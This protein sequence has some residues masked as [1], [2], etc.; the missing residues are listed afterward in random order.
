MNKKPDIPAF[1]SNG[2]IYLRA[3]STGIF[4]D[5]VHE[6]KHSPDH[7]VLGKTV[8][9]VQSKHGELRAY[10]AEREYQIVSGG[11]PVFNDLN[12]VIKHIK[13]NYK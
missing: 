13:K 10:S 11:K 3:S 5:L 6:G 7:L 8:A 1:Y 9:F 2:Q 4:D 12:D